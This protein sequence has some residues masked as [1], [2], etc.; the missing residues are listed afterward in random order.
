MWVERANKGATKVSRNK[1]NGCFF[2]GWKKIQ[3]FKIQIE[4]FKSKKL[5]VL[6]IILNMDCRHIHQAGDDYLSE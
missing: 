5:S 6:I 2:L 4:Q 1:V 3:L